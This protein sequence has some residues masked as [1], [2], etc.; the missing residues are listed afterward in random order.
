M[1][2]GL[3][4]GPGM[5]PYEQYLTAPAGHAPEAFVA[6]ALDNG[7]AY[8]SNLY[9]PAVSPHVLAVGGTSLT[10]L[11]AG[12]SYGS[13][14]AWGPSTG[15]ISPYFAQPAYQRGVVTQTS[16]YR[17]VPD[18]SY[19]ADNS[20]AGFAVYDP[21]ASL[22]GSGTGVAFPPPPAA[23]TFSGTAQPGG[24]FTGANPLPAPVAGVGLP[25][26][27]FLAPPDH[28]RSA[29]GGDVGMADGGAVETG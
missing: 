17:A 21:V 3:L 19:H 12:G 11:D 20:A 16:A 24:G 22:T 13:E 15:G 29:A 8:P 14:T 9:W 26:Q 4:Q 18:V 6:A 7:L 28:R 10:T 23:A 2:W 27:L 25:V 5:N 1:S